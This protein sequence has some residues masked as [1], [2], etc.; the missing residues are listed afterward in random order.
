MQKLRPLTVLALSALLWLPFAAQA[1]APS[2][3]RSVEIET[4]EVTRPDVAVSPDGEWM[5][6][7][8]L[9]HLFRLP[10]E[11]GTAEQL[12]F[13]PYFDSDP[14]ISPDGRQV[15][16]ASDRDGKSDGNLFV[17]DLAGGDIR[18]LTQEWWAARPVWSPDGGSIAYL[19]YEP[20]GLWAEY[21]FVDAMGVLAQVRRVSSQGGT[22]ET[23]TDA[24]GLIRSTFYLPD[25]R[26]AWTRL[27]SGEGETRTHDL[28]THARMG[29]SQ[30]RIE[31]TTTQGAVS[32]LLTVAGVVDRVVAD[33]AGGGLYVRRYKIPTSGFLVPQP[34]E[35]AY[36][37][38]NGQEDRAI[39]PLISPQPRPGFSVSEGTVYLGEQGTLWQIDAATGEREAISVSASIKMEVFSSSPPPRYTPEQGPLPSSILDPRL[40]PDG[41]SL[42]FT[43]A[44][45]LWQQPLNGGPAR[46]LF[47]DEGFQWGAAALSPDSRRVA[48]QHSKGNLQ[49]LQIG[50]LESGQTKTLVIVDRTGRFEPAWS[51]DGKQIVYVGFTS[52]KPSLFVVDAETG[53]R[54]KIV[55][56]FPRYMPRPQFSADGA[57]VYYTSVNQVFRYALH[58]EGKPEP[59]TE[60]NGGHVADGMV[61]PDGQWLAFRRNEEIW[62]APMSGQPV[63]DAA[64][65]RLTDDGGFNVSFAPDSRALIYATGA[66]VWRHPVDGGE[67]VEIP[68]H[69]E[70]PARA[71][72]ALLIRNVRVL[73][74]EA[75]DFTEA[76][77]MLIDQGRIQWIGAEAGRALPEGVKV[78]EAEGRYA[79]PGLFDMHTHVATPIHFNPARDVSNMAS[80]LAFGVTSVRDMGSDI[81]LVKAWNDRR[82]KYGKPVPRI[83]SGG[84]M[85]EVTKPFF[86]GGSF[87]VKTE[88]QAREIVRK[89]KRDGAM[90]IKSYFTLP[91]PLHRVIADEA[92]RQGMPVAAHGLI[93]REMVMGPV[94][95]RATI[96]HQPSPIR[97]Y[98]D[99]LKL[100]A[101]T[102]TRWD[103]TFAALGGN[104]ILFAQQP[105]LLSAA[106]LRAFTSRSDYALAE[107][108]ELFSILDPVIIGRAYAAQLASMR[109][110]HAMGVSLL[111]GT[112][113]LNPNVF[114]GH[115][116]H[117]E[118]RHLARSGIPPLDVLRLATHEAATTVGA[119][120]VLG[121]LEPGKLA[122]IVLLDANPLLDIRHAMD[123]WRVIQGGRVFASKP[124]LTEHR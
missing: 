63:T 47:E 88:E 39:T 62:V 11:G 42:I 31:V 48:Y 79:I 24:P 19:S 91:W 72:G 107:E 93:F 104:G 80:N 118:L 55:D 6:F 59:I 101:E 43:A 84:A 110:A 53:Q 73:D 10:V 94:L 40:A 71:P 52:S 56:S 92:R 85:T 114:Y 41:E 34:E 12:T 108:V 21:E 61:S 122:D 13:G 25:G 67:R 117:M 75:G 38:L 77:S 121:T 33:A 27:D 49:G 37:S 30:S 112:D 57:H 103:P 102:G 4:T 68:I 66:T 69:L 95:G 45:F 116:L 46:R 83:F 120:D 1:Q 113:A 58:G 50:D 111:A 36:V 2:E 109:Q 18:Q 70:L 15:V 17:L 78:V 35:I 74:F 115:G 22:S 3:T 44:G 54:T 97:V 20:K 87:F 98:A 86:H 5:I 119:G 26:L 123:I 96:E 32:T 82:V 64:A 65:T 100:L 51:P 23:L 106:K 89:E 105:H 28:G 76:T 60:F 14:A 124:E 99:I 29:P 8:A 16:F 9:G 90:A 81:T 7:T